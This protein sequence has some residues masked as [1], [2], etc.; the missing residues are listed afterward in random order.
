MAGE[1]EGRTVMVAGA[2]SGMGKAVAIRAAGEGARLIL[3][4]RDPQRLEET[5]T[6]AGSAEMT[7]ILGDAS[8]AGSLAAAIAPHS[9]AI[10]TVDV[11]I[12]SVGMNIVKRDFDSLTNDS[13]A[14]MLDTNLTAAFN[15]MQI[16]I[17]G[18][19][20]RR[21]GLV[22]NIASTAA[23]KADLSGAAYQAS[24]AGVLALNHAVMEEEWKNGIRLTAILPGMTD[25]PLLDR[26]PTPVPP[27]ARAAAL[28]PEDIAEACMFVM[29]LPPRA[30]IAEILIQPAQR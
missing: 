27:E 15:L 7:T 19:R 16:V 10:E 6:A 20:A 25:T 17:P 9:I 4:A 28:Q 12:N 23:R 11:L 22:I 8:N 2:S 13:W 30:H 3:L 21:Q 1:L 18:M 5:R 26:R 29:R 24:K 14:S